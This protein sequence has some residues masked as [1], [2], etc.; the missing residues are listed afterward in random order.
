VDQ[1]VCDVIQPVPCSPQIQTS[2]HFQLSGPTSLSFPLSE[3]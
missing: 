1:I 3:M 2:N